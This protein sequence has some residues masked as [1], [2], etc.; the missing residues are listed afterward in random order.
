MTSYEG[1]VIDD[2]RLMTTR[3]WAYEDFVLKEIYFIDKEKTNDD[4]CPDVNKYI[5]VN[6]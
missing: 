3:K 6:Y 2:H 5:Y 1:K 4:L